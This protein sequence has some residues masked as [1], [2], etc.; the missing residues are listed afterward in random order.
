MSQLGRWGR[1]A[2]SRLCHYGVTHP[3]LKRIRSV[4]SRLPKG[5]QKGLVRQYLDHGSAVKERLMQAILQ[6]KPE[7]YDWAFDQC[8]GYAALA[9]LAKIRRLAGEQ[10]GRLKPGVRR[11][12]LEGVLGVRDEQ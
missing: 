12:L 6:A 5:G 8:S 9:R 4:A 11:R 10:S 2:L 7:L 3:A 1:Y